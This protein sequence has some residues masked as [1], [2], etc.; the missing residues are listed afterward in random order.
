MFVG[1]GRAGKTSLMNALLGLEFDAN[2]ETTIGLGAT[3]EC[4]VRR[5]D[6]GGWRAK[7]TQEG[8][9]HYPRLIA[10]TAAAKVRR[11]YDTSVEQRAVEKLVQIV[12]GK[13]NGAISC[14]KQ[15]RSVVSKAVEELGN[16]GDEIKHRRVSMMSARFVEQV[17]GELGF[18][19]LEATG[20]EPIS[21]GGMLRPKSATHLQLSRWC[22]QPVLAKVCFHLDAAI[23]AAETPPYKYSPNVDYEEACATTQQDAN[24]ATTS[25]AEGIEPLLQ[26][27]QGE[28]P[29]QAGSKDQVVIGELELQIES[30]IA[31]ELESESQELIFHVWDYGGQQVFYNMHHLFLS[32]YGVYCC[33]FNMHS[34]LK[35][36]EREDAI[37]YLRFWLK[38]IRMHA[39]GAPFFLVGT[40]KDLYPAP[41]SHRE[42]NDI[43]ESVDF[44][45]S[46]LLHHLCINEHDDLLFYPVDNTSSAADPTLQ[47]LRECIDKFAR[48]DRVEGEE[49]PYVEK[50]IPT[51]WVSALDTLHKQYRSEA[52]VGMDAV[53]AV[54]RGC[55]VRVEDTQRML[56]LFHELG[57]L[58]YWGNSAVN[59]RKL[60]DQVILQPQHLID[61][62]CMVL[63]DHRPEVQGR[64]SKARKAHLYARLKM[65]S[66][67]RA[68]T[69][70]ALMSDKLLTHLWSSEED[71]VS[72]DQEYF[73]E[74]MLNFG[75]M[76]RWGSLKE[77]SAVY[78]VPSVMALLPDAPD[79][80]LD[81]SSQSCIAFDFSAQHGGFFLPTGLFEH[82]ICEL[83]AE[84]D[85][86][87]VRQKPKLHRNAAQVCLAS[88]S[89]QDLG[90]YCELR[91]NDQTE[92][93]ELSVQEGGDPMRARATVEALL[94]RLRED[95]RG[96]R[97]E[98]VDELRMSDSGYLLSWKVMLV[99]GDRAVEEKDFLDRAERAGGWLRF[100]REAGIN[101][102]P[103]LKFRRWYEAVEDE[104]KAEQAGAPSP[105]A[106]LLTVGQ[107]PAPVPL[108]QGKKWDF[109]ISHRQQTG[110]HIAHSLHHELGKQGSK[111]WIDTYEQG[112][113]SHLVDGIRRSRAL[114]LVLT[115]GV[116][117]RPWCRFEVRTAMIWGVP[118]FP[119]HE[120]D[121]TKLGYF[122]DWGKNYGADDLDF[123][124]NQ[125]ES[126]AWQRK[127]WLIPGVLDRLMLLLQAHGH[128][129]REATDEDV[130]CVKA[131]RDFDEATPPIKQPQ[132]TPAPESPSSGLRTLSDLSGGL[133]S[134]G[135]GSTHLKTLT[136]IPSIYGNN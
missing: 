35:S 3:Q 79:L 23:S 124:F 2:Q 62:V 116:L 83:V 49:Y 22:K 128:S 32:R 19:F 56:A 58:V 88:G 38:S 89:D 94:V 52:A 105:G 114:I 125:F 111:T 7:P 120:A 21:T 37:S 135:T 47:H 46:G 68:L 92:R 133:H 112:T 48:E 81:S 100:T 108:V 9:E 71:G 76:C 99:A 42:I 122:D 95:T 85:A 103:F 134:H 91:L 104:S 82:L 90:T 1:E 80:A 121:S 63:R 33:V 14:L 17:G 5:I 118:I 131:N 109:F 53:R 117:T 86:G 115:A 113:G 78:F 11:E 123:V 59:W 18:E 26:Q 126:T 127:S 16:G 65:S 34:L 87:S 136:L 50:R 132:S 101:S 67:W 97:K 30:L 4:T 66:E 45:D 70:G 107:E 29:L 27:Q 6:V 20:W 13:G 54:A 12:D 51:T 119:V 28:K 130:A 64:L 60:Q 69:E 57:V 75:L 44:L 129:Y 96:C 93:I 73:I 25:A 84:A 15:L 10:R 98:Q 55:G 77:E 72:Y 39:N 31:E 43:L 106:P 110:E 41:R 36:D 8:S 24:L 74:M 61:G 40:H 102:S